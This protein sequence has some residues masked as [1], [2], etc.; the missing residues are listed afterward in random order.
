MPEV[1]SGGFGHADPVLDPAAGS[2][3]THEISG[4]GANGAPAGAP[5]DAPGLSKLQEAPSPDGA[6][7]VPDQPILPA[8][9]H[10]HGT[11]GSPIHP[12]IA[13]SPSSSDIAKLLGRD[14]LGQQQV[15]MSPVAKPTSAGS[16]SESD[17]QRLAAASSL[18][19]R[20]PAPTTLAPLPELVDQ[21]WKVVNHLFG[22]CDRAQVRAAEVGDVLVKLGWYP[23]N[24]DYNAIG[25]ALGKH[26]LRLQR[27]VVRGGGHAYL[28]PKCGQV[29]QEHLR[30]CGFDA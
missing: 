16:L 9:S 19:W 29:T 23:P 2:D 8:D 10:P 17:L 15:V 14:Q 22:A 7:D 13:N 20:P 5:A 12:N 6:P 25:G 27:V 11:P 21:S 1:E 18:D 28:R 30:A 4:V 3:A 26:G 24:K